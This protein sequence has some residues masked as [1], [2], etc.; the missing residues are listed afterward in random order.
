M[1]EINIQSDNLDAFIQKVRMELAKRIF[2]AASL[3]RSELKASLST[4]Y[5]PAS[6]PGEFPHAR[7][8]QGRNAVVISPSDLPTI[9]KTLKVRVG[10]IQNA[11]Y[12]GIL[13]E[14]KGRLGLF[15]LF[16]QV[17]PQLT[18]ILGGHGYATASR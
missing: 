2:A 5:P 3:L 8:Y 16:E 11:F 10:Y 9:A 7:T 1:A 18:A 13:E 6:V 4:A 17:K 12:M 14:S 15:Y